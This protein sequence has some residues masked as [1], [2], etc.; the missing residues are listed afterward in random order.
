MSANLLDLIPI[1]I[2]KNEE[3]NEDGTI[4]VF[5]PKFRNKFMIK[6]IMPKLKSPDFKVKLDEFGSF[7]W[8]QIDGN[9]TVE[10]IG[11]NLKDNFHE[12]IEPV[13][14]RLSVYFQTLLRYKFIEYK[15]YDPKQDKIIN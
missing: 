9:L 11:L 13:Y 12:N 15:N 8:K 2:M 4:T 14:E 5:K 10:E 1:K 6:Y 3:K 7:V